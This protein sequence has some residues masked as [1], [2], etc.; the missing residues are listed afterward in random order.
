MNSY[1]NELLAQHVPLM[2]VAG[3]TEG[4]QSPAVASPA[5]SPPG[6]IGGGAPLGETISVGSP[7]VER[8]SPL[9]VAG[10]ESSDPFTALVAQLRS[11]LSYRKR[12]T[13]WDPNRS[14][15]FQIVLVDK[16]RL[17]MV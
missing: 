2:F 7:G 6:S 16:V 17:C 15:V 11:V 4:T 3:L 10:S 12:G 5:M 8:G 13:V 1:P 9:E 14:K